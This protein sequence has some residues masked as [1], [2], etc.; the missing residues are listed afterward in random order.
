M[1][2]QQTK[3]KTT[4]TP[5]RLKVKENRLLCIDD[6]DDEYFNCTPVNKILD[7]PDVAGN[8]ERN[9][10]DELVYRNTARDILCPSES[11]MTSFNNRPNS[12]ALTNKQQ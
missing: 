4:A 7:D 11:G 8:N 5:T 12:T 2:H 9:F 3:D 10:N 1:E 6:A